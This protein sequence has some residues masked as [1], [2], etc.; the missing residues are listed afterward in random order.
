[1][2]TKIDVAEAMYG[3]GCIMEGTKQR[4]LLWSASVIV[5]IWATSAAADSPKLNGAYGFT[6]TA[7]CLAAPGSGTKPTPGNT[8]PFSNAGFNALLQPIDSAQ[9]FSH[10]FA[11]EG[12][13][14]FNGDGTGTVNGT[15]VGITPRPTPG[16]A[17]LYP[18]FP[19]DAGSE[20]FTYNFTYTVNG[21]GSWSST[22]VPGSYQGTFVTGPR[23]TNNPANLTN[24]T[25][26]VDAIPPL[27]G[28]ISQDGMTLIVAHT[29]TTVETR[30]FSNGDVWP[31]ICHRSRVL[32][33]LPNGN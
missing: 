15:S 19:P 20:T 29:T 16:P 31:E 32:I 25:V 4:T 11:V 22:M 24:Q 21:D 9:S 17:P 30:T 13:R 7:E 1:M 27:T 26:T 6:G 5:A 3:E 14:T 33:S 23:S 8:S 12:I 28:L 10:S 2:Q 18:N